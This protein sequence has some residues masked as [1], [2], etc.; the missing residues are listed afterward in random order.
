M[1]HGWGAMASNGGP[2]LVLG[3][4]EFVSRALGK[5]IARKSCQTLEQLIDEGCRRFAVTTA[6]LDSALHDPYA[7]RVRAWIAHQAM[8]RRIAS[9]AAVAR[10][11]G[12]NEATLRYAI[13]R[14]CQGLE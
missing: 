9:L 12:R 6:R 13:R 4:E 5:S 7:S 10:A 8:V 2:E 14:Y 3:N 11:L 1:S